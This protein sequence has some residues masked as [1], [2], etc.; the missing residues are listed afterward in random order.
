[1]TRGPSMSRSAVSCEHFVSLAHLDEVSLPSKPSSRRL[2]MARCRSLSAACHAPPRSAPCED[3]AEGV[4]G[5]VD[6]PLQAG[7]KPFQPRRHI[8]VALLR[9]FEHVVIGL[10]LLADLR[11]HAVEALRAFFR[12]G[13]RHVGDRAR[14]AAVAV[15]EGVDRDEPEMREAGLQHGVKRLL[16]VRT[17]PG[18]S[19]F[20]HRVVRQPAP[21]KC[22]RSRPT[23]PE[24]TCIG[25]VLSSRQAPTVISSCRCGPS[26]KARHAS[27]T[28]APHQGLV[29]IS[30]WRRASSRRRLQHYGPRAQGR[31]C[32]CR[33]G[34]RSRSGPAPGPDS[35]LRSR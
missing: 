21:R 17:N 31:R 24:I 15:V 14:D 26:E 22:T 9:C 7:E 8:E 11:R 6:G 30:A 32:P 1:M 19:A 27:R 34:A 25:P 18:M 35:R 13:Q 3:A 5:A 33:G 28:G 2:T 29:I 4:F 23:G 10:A 20:R 16:R 12:T